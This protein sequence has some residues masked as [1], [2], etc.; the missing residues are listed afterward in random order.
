MRNRSRMEKLT[1]CMEDI[2]RFSE[3]LGVAQAHIGVDRK[4]RIRVCLLMEEVLLQMRDVLG[5]EAGLSASC[6]IRF[7]RLRLR[8][9]V[10]GRP[11]NPLGDVDSEFGAWDCSLRTAIG[12]L[13]QYSYENGANTLRLV[14]PNAQMNPVLRIAIA[15]VLG[16]MIGLAGIALIPEDIRTLIV[17]IVL[18][19]TYEMWSR[20]LNA[21]SGPIVFCTVVT[22]MFNTRSIDERGGSSMWVIARYFLLSVLVVLVA[23]V[24]ALPFFGVELVDLELSP[25]LGK[26][27]YRL[28]AAVIP[29]NIIDPLVESNTSQLLFLAFVLGYVLMRL[30][31]RTALLRQGI[32]EANIIGLDL[33]R[34]V[35]WLVPVFTEV[36]LCLELWQGR[37]G[38]LRGMWRPLVIAIGIAAVILV[39]SELVLARRLHVRPA[40]L[41]LKLWPAFAAA[42][43]TGSLDGSFAEVQS[44]STDSLGINADYLKVGLPQGLVLY[45]PNSAVGTIVF[46]LFVTR[47]SSVLGANLLWYASAIIMTVVVFVATPPVP[48]ANLLAY[49]VLFQTL[50]IPDE[51]LLDA[52]V[53]DI[54]FGIFAGAANQAMLQL[55]MTLQASKLG[56]CDLDVLRGPVAKGR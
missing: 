8:V 21:I 53:F 22:T 33:A 4:N 28:V 10:M 14:L 50:G 42:M 43:R 18:E 51:A 56:L 48:G 1:L 39:L 12:L 31:E 38:L 2:D 15:I 11:Y 54:V 25:Q 27:V 16:V 55:E 40:R 36:F 30:G 6:D 32:Q 52:M 24:C 47:A 23:L 9:Q 20:L 17:D 3:W 44:S 19:P 34:A 7:G 29:A 45:M 49:V 5:E 35:S 13:P 26:Q 46:T 41:M 37:T